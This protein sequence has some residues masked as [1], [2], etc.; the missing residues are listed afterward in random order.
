MNNKKITSLITALTTCFTAI[1]INPCCIKAETANMKYEYGVFLGADPEDISYMNNYKKI[2]IDAQYFENDEI[3]KLK[4][5]GHTVY[6]Y[7]NLGS[8]EKFRPYYKKYKKYSLGTYENWTDEKWIDV[9]QKEWQNF[10]VGELAKEILDK[11]VDGLWVDNCDVY[12]NFQNDKIYNGVTDI[13]MGLKAYDTYV[14]INGGDTYVSKYAEE[15]KSLNAVM[16]A[17]NQETVFSAIDWDNDLFTENDDDTR[18]YFQDYCKLVSDYGKDVYLLEY[19]ENSDIIDKVKNYCNENGYTYYASDTLDLLTP[20]QEKGSQPLTE[21]TPEDETFIDP[22]TLAELGPHGTGEKVSTFK[23]GFWE[24][25]YNGTALSEYIYFDPN[26]KDFISFSAECGLKENGEYSLE[27]NLCT[28]TFATGDV[29]KTSASVWED[30]ATL[31]YPNGRIDVMNYISAVSPDDFDYLCNAEIRELLINYYEKKTGI[32][33]NPDCI[34]IKDGFTTADVYFTEDIYCNEDSVF[35]CY[36]IDRFTGKCVDDNGKEIK[37]DNTLNKGTYFAKGLWKCKDLTNDLEGD[38]YWFSGN[39][40]DSV[41][42]DT[43]NKDQCDFNYHISNGRGIA[44]MND[45]VWFFTCNET[46]DSL[47]IT[48][49]DSEG[50][51]CTEKLTFIGTAEK[52]EVVWNNGDLIISEAESES[53]TAED[54]Q[55]LKNFLLGNYCNLGNKNYDFNND[56]ILNIFDLIELRKIVSK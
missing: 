6:S 19:T 33:L 24:V 49:Y 48:W 38:Y 11:G 37:L 36:N 56:G 29:V 18:E 51:F 47:I 30:R 17:V 43:V 12:Y 5:S 46:D 27:N 39:E 55:L 31:N 14:I 2:V 41:S 45:D 34:M 16:D 8:V 54:V 13:L 42:Y 25:R 26:G 53:Y 4:E 50:A 32:L 9:S 52:N 40:E 44:Y 10:V 23:P 20:G 35:Q 1:S 22:D 7:I 28:K 15:N 21:L 3:S